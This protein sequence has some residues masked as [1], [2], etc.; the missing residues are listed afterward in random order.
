VLTIDGKESCFD[1]EL[2]RLI[3]GD[4]G[5]ARRPVD[6]TGTDFD[7]I[8]GDLGSGSYDAVISGATITP[9]RVALFSDPYLESEQGLVVNAAQPADQIHRRS[10]PDYSWDRQQAGE[11]A[12][13]AVLQVTEADNDR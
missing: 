2:M 5:L 11:R 12:R 6:Y 10:N 7:G 1:I 13:P 8:F 3:C 4:L 9:E